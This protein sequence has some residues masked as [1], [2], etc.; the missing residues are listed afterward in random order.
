[1]FGG[2]GGVD[3]Y[4]EE[5]RMLYATYRPLVSDYVA[6]MSE[7]LQQEAGEA[8]F[9][10]VYRKGLDVVAWLESD[11]EVPDQEYM[12][13]VPVSI[14]VV[15]L[16]Q[17]M[18]VMV[19]FKT[20]GISPGEL[21][22]SFEAIAGHSQ[23]IAT[24]TALSLATDEESFYRVSKI[25][26]GLLMLT[27]VYPQLDYPTAAASAQSIAATPMVSV[28]KLSR[29]QIAEAI[30]KHN[31]QQKTDKAMVHLSLT[32]GA[33]MFVVSG[34][35]ESIKGFVRALYKE[36]DTGGAD[37]TRVRHSQRKSGVST[38]YLSINA[39][40]HCPLLGHAVE[41]A[42]RYAS[43]KG[44]ELDSRDM[45]RAVRAGDDGHDIRGVGN[46]S[47]YLLQ[48]MC[49]LPVDWCKAAGMDGV[50]HIVDFGPGG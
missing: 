11:E 1:M 36:H 41:G 44:W 17:L 8:A 23:G 25:V 19:L 5:T 28:L 16:T 30:S 21:A 47:Q 4:I 31:A 38:K 46:L 48:S 33:K 15:G 10:Q 50:T 7:F 42:C 14:P 24:A 18:Q 13:S 39:P 9:S 34:A 45:R 43:S 22:S 20:L 27:G 37:Q 3:N 49:V 26:L 2:Q 32:N 40:Y 35:T 12:L 29:A 6:C